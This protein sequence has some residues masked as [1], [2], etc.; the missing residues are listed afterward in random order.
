MNCANENSSSHAGNPL[1]T[2][3]T[4]ELSKKPHL[5]KLDY[6]SRSLDIC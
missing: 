4:A 3:D 1:D 6:T 2:Q 5:V